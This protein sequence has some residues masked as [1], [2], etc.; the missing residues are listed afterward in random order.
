MIAQFSIIMVVLGVI[1]F[2]R[3]IKFGKAGNVQSIQEAK[4]IVQTI[5]EIIFRGARPNGLQVA[6]LVI[7]FVA[8]ILIVA[9]NKKKDE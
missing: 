2:S 3:A 6:G 7:G 8:C 1:L 4:A 5:L 9:Q